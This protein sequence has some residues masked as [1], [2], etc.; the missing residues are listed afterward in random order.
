MEPKTKHWTKKEM[1]IYVLLLCAN[2]DTVE[3]QEE[4]DL[5]KSKVNNETF[6][7]VYK[8]FSEDTGE[9][10]FEKIRDCVA[11][12]DYCYREIS[13]LKKDMQEIFF[14]DKKFL[15]LERNL[16]GILNNIIY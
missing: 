15:M 6:E 10:S 7:K 9:E 4:L 3:T 14:T 2:A 8:E 13:E 11:V 16:E 1:Q 12:H 5:I